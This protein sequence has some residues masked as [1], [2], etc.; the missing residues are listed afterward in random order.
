MNTI[1]QTEFILPL[2]Y[3]NNGLLGGEWTN[4]SYFLLQDNLVAESS[5]SQ[6]ATCDIMLSNF[7]FNIPVGAVVT[8]IKFKVRGYV[9]AITV[10]PA[11]LTFNAVD[12][13]SGSILYY[14]Y[15]APFDGFTQ[16]MA[17]YEFGSENYLFDTDWT[18][19][20]INNFKLQLIGAGD[21]F[22]DDVVV[23][24]FYY[25]PSV[26][27]DP[28]PPSDFCLSCDSPIQGVE[29]FLALELTSTDTKAYV[30]DFNYADGTPIEI[31]DLGE[32]GGSLE[33][34]LDEGKISINGNNFMENARIIDI[35]RLP[36]GLVELDFGSLDNRGLGFHTPYTHDA[37]LVSPH[38]INA[39]LII[40]NNGPF[41]DKYVR[42]CQEDIV[43]SPP[44]TVSDENVE[45]EETVH[46][47]DF[48][49]AGVTAVNDITDPHKKIITIPGA[50]GT[51]PPV[52]VATGSNTS[53]STKVDELTYTLAFSGVNRGAIIQVSTE[54]GVTVTGITVGGVP[55]TQEIVRTDAPNNLRH[56]SWSV[57]AVPN[58][59]QDV[60]VSLS[61]IAYICSGAES[62]V[63]VDQST[64]VASTQSAAGTSNDV[65]QV[66]TTTEDN[67]L[68]IDGLTTA[69]TPILYTA[70][71]GQSENWHHTANTDTRQGA[72][73]Y[74]PAG[75]QPD[76]VTMRWSLT[77]STAWVAT[78]VELKG[79]TSATPPT[80]PIEVQDEGTPVD[81][82]TTV[83]NFTGNGVTAT[84]TSPGE[85]EVNI[86][87]TPAGSQ[88]A[89]QFENEGVNLGAPGDVAE[90]DFVGAGVNATRS[91]N[92]VTINIPG[93]SAPSGPLAA[94]IEMMFKIGTTNTA[95][96]SSQ[97][98]KFSTKL[99]VFDD[100]SLTFMQFGSD[101]ITGAVTQDANPNFFPLPGGYSNI[102][103]RALTTSED[104]TKLYALTIATQSFGANPLWTLRTYNT[105]LALTQTSTYTTTAGGQGQGGLVPFFVYN[106]GVDDHMV[107]ESC[108]HSIL[109]ADGFW[110]DWI[111]A[112][113][114]LTTPQATNLKFCNA[115]GTARVDYIVVTYKQGNVY[116]QG[117]G[118]PVV[119]GVE[120][121]A[122]ATL[123]FAAIAGTNSLAIPNFTYPTTTNH[124]GFEIPNSTT[125]GRWRNT[126]F[127]VTQTGGGS[128]PSITYLS[129][130]YN[131][132]TF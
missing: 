18:V 110:T 13:L 80:N 42:R 73:S 3:I 33:I 2:A 103:G 114:S 125:I 37:A 95:Q 102:V 91:V 40:S 14:P 22:I 15:T 127:Y 35:S 32:C 98:L 109:A 19:D 81:T 9:G 47:I 55:A 100:V 78:S 36:S 89:I 69:Q 77:Q 131:N 31:T 25:V 8:G 72:S 58:G 41:Y 27:P 118:S 94:N 61:A 45:L 34:V 28:T 20:Q 119:E 117:P 126:S 64:P 97:I 50:G 122:Y 60:I 1:V 12:N 101:A 46:D 11:T 48:R 63:G 38:G 90:V 67:S 44:I 43:F 30:Y 106:D 82:N 54:Q 6:G 75:S 26:T 71:S 16:S 116:M 99:F 85:V 121:R 66:L 115:G 111:I 59:V 57:V 21:I 7:N 65:L 5:P 132:Y 88:D 123:T 39:K 70:Y 120:K 104:G 87:A 92:K 107:S 93:A 68:V 130:I 79:I 74:Q 113:A 84:Q 53:G 62:F 10:P 4:P 49:G 124:G 29:Y 96:Y 129:A 128:P 112:G 56:E 86:P 76:A 17:E 51:T 108:N 23:Q 83:F 105:S 52:L 24:I